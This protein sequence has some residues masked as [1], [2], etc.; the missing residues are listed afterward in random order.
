MLLLI[1][2]VD[3]LEHLSD[4]LRPRVAE[5]CCR[6]PLESCRLPLMRPGLLLLSDLLPIRGGLQRH[7][8]INS[9]AHHDWLEF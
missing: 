6:D 9:L 3:R 4:V 8:I 2:H 5:F 1:A 7:L